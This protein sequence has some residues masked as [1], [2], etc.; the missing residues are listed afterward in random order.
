MIALT[1]TGHYCMIINRVPVL[2]E[3]IFGKSHALTYRGSANGLLVALITFAL[4]S[5]FMSGPLWNILHKD[6]SRK[7]GHRTLHL[8][9][10]S[11]KV[12]TIPQLMRMSGLLRK[13]I[14]KLEAQAVC[15]P[16]RESHC[17]ASRMFTVWW[18]FGASER[19]LPIQRHTYYVKIIR[20]KSNKTQLTWAAFRCTFAGSIRAVWNRVFYHRNKYC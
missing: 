3:S 16:I 10:I 6:G 19:L 14:C 8:C 4:K 12:L 17:M 18:W 13:W 7:S 5:P 9:F 2:H 1:S 15:F 20:H 11:S